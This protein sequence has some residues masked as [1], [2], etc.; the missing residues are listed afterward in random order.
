M[1]TQLQT[2]KGHETWNRAI[3]M[4]KSS[5]DKVITHLTYKTLEIMSKEIEKSQRKGY[6]PD[7]M[8]RFNEGGR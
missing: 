5:V 3:V 2:P 1:S 8:R 6:D 7:F 4:N